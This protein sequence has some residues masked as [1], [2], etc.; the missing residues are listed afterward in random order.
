MDPLFLLF[1]ARNMI[2]HLNGMMRRGSFKTP[3]PM[4]HILTWTSRWVFL[5][6]LCLEKCCF[7]FHW[8]FDGETLSFV[9]WSC[10]NVRHCIIDHVVMLALEHFWSVI[11]LVWT[12]LVTY[13]I[14]AILTICDVIGEFWLGFW[15]HWHCEKFV[16]QAWMN[17]FMMYVGNFAGMCKFYFMNH[18]KIF[19][20]MNM[21]KFVGMENFCGCG[22]ILWARN[23][24]YG[25]ILLNMWC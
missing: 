1:M 8:K 18:S 19:V 7:M 2:H 10:W 6:F 25:K 21:E 5:W 15:G 20:G 11:F 3:R 16:L 12:M 9:V 4:L 22:R 23:F 13:G 17:L 14:L 24:G